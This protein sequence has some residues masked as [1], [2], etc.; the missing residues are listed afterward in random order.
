VPSSSTS[1]LKTSQNSKTIAAGAGA[2]VL[3]KRPCQALGYTTC[4]FCSQS[5]IHDHELMEHANQEHRR[6]VLKTW[7]KCEMC[8]AYFP[9][10]T[11]VGRH[12]VR[13][14]FHQIRS[15]KKQGKSYYN[16]NRWAR[17]AK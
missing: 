6:L 1:Q 15:M 12:K 3:Q 2:I 13:N 16:S 17:S 10:L 5:F 4:D 11:F 7:I 8:P 14:H 9:N